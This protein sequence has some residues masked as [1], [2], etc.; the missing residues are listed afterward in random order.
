MLREQIPLLQEKVYLDTASLAPLARPVE[1]AM[2]GYLGEWGSEGS[3][4]Y[5]G[6]SS[7]LEETRK[8]AASLVNAAPENMA[9]V[10][11]TSQGVNLAAA[12]SSLSK[13]DK[14]LVSEGDFPANVLPFRNLESR[15]IKVEFLSPCPTPEEVDGA[16]DREVRLVSLS[17]VN[18]RTGYRVEVEEVGKLCSQNGALFH[19]DAIQGLGV[20]D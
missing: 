14:V 1:G 5:E 2:K 13:G 15:G 20:F 4:A 10:S 3:L 18:Y 8:L 12:L 16:M 7:K 17:F 19:L 6:W 11:S 9:F